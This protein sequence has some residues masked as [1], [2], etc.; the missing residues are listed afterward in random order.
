MDKIWNKLLEFE[1][2]DLVKSYFKRVHNSNVN[3]WKVR[4]VTA[5]FIQGREY[6]KSAELANITIK[7]LLL[8]YGVLSLS[9]GLILTLKPR[10]KEQALKKSHGISISNWDEALKSKKFENLKISVGDGSLLELIEATK[11]INYLKATVNA[12]NFKSTLRIPEKGYNVTL[13]HLYWYLPDLANE[14][15]VWTNSSFPSPIAVVPNAKY[16]DESNRRSIRLI[17]GN[18]DENFINLVFPDKYCSNIEINEDSEDSSYFYISYDNNG[19][20]PNITQKWDG[21]FGIGDAC[22]VPVLADNKGFNTVSTMYAL[23]YIYGMMA[24]YYPSS[25][26]S[27]GR[28]EKG[29]RIYPL[30]HRTLSFIES[31]FP[32]VVLDFL[33]A[34]YEFKNKTLDTNSIYN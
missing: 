18:I 17:K 15:E 2:K 12:I 16:D 31:K 27:L 21:P 23:S 13:E 29:D 4:E 24:R 5:N 11:N 1:T 30:I 33:R 20:M 6:F 8:Y 28:V 25:W 14:F 34:P 19:W 9:R 22:T 3:D 10:L 7:P 26:I 32:V